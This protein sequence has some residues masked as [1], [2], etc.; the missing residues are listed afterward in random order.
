MATG[1]FVA[2]AVLGTNPEAKHFPGIFL[3]AIAVSV[4]AVRG[5]R[6]W[7]VSGKTL[8]RFSGVFPIIRLTGRR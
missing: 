2:A 8:P 7:D 1:V 6:S 4:I 5:T 3:I